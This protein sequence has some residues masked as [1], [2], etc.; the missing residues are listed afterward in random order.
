VY[1]QIGNV[2]QRHLSVLKSIHVACI[3]KSSHVKKYGLQ[4]VLE[5]LVNDVSSF[6]SVGIA[7]T[8]DGNVHR[9]FASLATV[10]ADNLASHEI[11]GF[12]MCFSSGHVCRFCMIRSEHLTSFYSE[13]N[14]GYPKLRTVQRH[15]EHTAA[16]ARDSSLSSAYGVVKQSPLHP[17]HSFHAA[18]SLPPDCMHD[19]FEGVIPIV[20]KVCL[21]GLIAEKIFNLKVINDRLQ[22]FRF[23]RNDVKNVPPVI[24][25]SFPKSSIPGSAAQKWCLFRNLAFIIGD[26]VPSSSKF[27]TLYLLCRKMVEIIFA[28]SVTVSQVSYLDLLVSQH[29]TM[30]LQLAPEEFTPKC[31]YLTHY[32]RLISVYGPVRHCGACDLK[33]I[34]ST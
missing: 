9:L 24:P 13:T 25:L 20:L 5:R 3:A 15:N 16:V 17:L 12:R 1:F 8:V 14:E 6:E 10:S 2:E 29:H 27:W 4:K 26:L 21:R 32:P 7:V 33:D 31:H 18:S 11:G 22:Q 34:T 30:L 28:P 19:V 23:G